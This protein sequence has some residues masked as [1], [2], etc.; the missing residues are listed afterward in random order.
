MVQIVPR[1]S[2]IIG[3]NLNLARLP[4]PP[5]GPDNERLTNGKSIDLTVWILPLPSIRMLDRICSTKGQWQADLLL[6]RPVG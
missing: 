5:R 4:I 3:E 1:E 2:V 6:D